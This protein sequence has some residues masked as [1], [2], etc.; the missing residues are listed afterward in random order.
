M[1]IDIVLKV[2]SLSICY[3]LLAFSFFFFLKLIF[4]TNIKNI[5]RKMIN[6]P[7]ENN[8]DI[9]LHLLD[10]KY[11]LYYQHLRDEIE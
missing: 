9:D 5:Q 2:T 8:D 1:Y 4:K 10:L 7:Y 6:I 3:F 11:N